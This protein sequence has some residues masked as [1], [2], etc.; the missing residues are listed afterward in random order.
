MERWQQVSCVFIWNKKKI[1]VE[2]HKKY[3]ERKTINVYTNWMQKNGKAN[4]N[5]YFDCMSLVLCIPNTVRN[6]CA[7]QF[8]TKHNR[9]IAEHKPQFTQHTNCYNIGMFYF[10]HHATWLYFIHSL[11][12]TI[13]VIL[14]FYCRKVNFCCCCCIYIQK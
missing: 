1:F 5:M 8:V 14:F 10:T 11:H 12:Y 13:K 9:R 3:W 2:N 6:M 7:C 4:K